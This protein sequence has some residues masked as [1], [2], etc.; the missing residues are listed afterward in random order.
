VLAERVEWGWITETEA[1]AIATK[2]LR[3]NAA[4]LF[5]IELQERT[6]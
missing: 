4:E 3:T 6:P 2:I 5:G 1:A